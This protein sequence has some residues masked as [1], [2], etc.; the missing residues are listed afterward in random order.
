MRATC[1][2]SE[3]LRVGQGQISRIAR[4][5]V[6][7]VLVLVTVVTINRMDKGQSGSCGADKKTISVQYSRGVIADC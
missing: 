4:A 3:T 5:G 7:V 2:R 1:E 6:A